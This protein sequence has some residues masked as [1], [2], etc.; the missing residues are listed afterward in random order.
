MFSLRKSNYLFLNFENLLLIAARKTY[1]RK[2]SSFALA[3]NNRKARTT[4]TKPL[5][6]LR[7]G[8]STFSDWNQSHVVSKRSWSSSRIM[9]SGSAV[10]GNHFNIQDYDIIGFDLD[11]TLLR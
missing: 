4:T 10:S 9:E 5:K 1:Q 3:N 11:C 2:Q 6:L 8:N 7:N